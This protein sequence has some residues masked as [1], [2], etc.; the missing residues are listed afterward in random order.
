VYID[1][2]YVYKQVIQNKFKDIMCNNEI[3]I[4]KHD[5]SD[6]ELIDYKDNVIK[7]KIVTGEPMMF[8]TKEQ[9]IA[10]SE[11]VNQF[12]KIDIDNKVITPFEE[13][14]KFLGGI[15][16][17]SKEISILK[18]DPVLLHNDLVVGNILVDDQNIRLIDFEYSGYGNEIYDI[19]S[20]LTER[21]LPSDDEEFFTSLFNVDK[22]ELELVKKFLNEF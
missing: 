11:A 16:D 9:L 18:R 14:Y 2:K 22:N 1:D 10:I 8:Y 4:I 5:D 21:E 12:H 20:F 7:M 15:R 19:A 13:A 6:V 3:E 17:I